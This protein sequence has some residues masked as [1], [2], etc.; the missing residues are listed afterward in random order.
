MSLPT[1][2][3]FCLITSQMFFCQTGDLIQ[4][5]ALTAVAM[6]EEDLDNINVRK[7]DRTVLEV[8]IGNELLEVEHQTLIRRDGRFDIHVSTSI[9]TGPKERVL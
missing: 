6:K 4:A 1:C 3:S 8:V 7:S 9:S 5:T 2:D